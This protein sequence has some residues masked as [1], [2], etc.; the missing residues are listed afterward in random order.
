MSLNIIK[1]T[2]KLQVFEKI[3]LEII[4]SFPSDKCYFYNNPSIQ[5]LFTISP[6]ICNSLNT[7]T[8][9][10]ILSN[11]SSGV[12][13]GI[14]SGVSS[15]VSS[16]IS[17]GVSSGNSNYSTS[18]CPNSSLYPTSIITPNSSNIIC[19][20]K[21]SKSNSNLV[22]YIIITILVLIIFILLYFVMNK[23]FE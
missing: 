16:G 23:K 4:S 8:T 12:S 9:S 13:S 6:D 17:S 18:T 11:I 5:Q 15:G 14:S 21:I 20:D 2:S 1:D 10:N 7:Q 22:F 3:I 19:S